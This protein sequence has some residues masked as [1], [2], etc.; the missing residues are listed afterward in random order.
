[1]HVTC[2]DWIYT[3]LYINKLTASASENSLLVTTSAIWR[4]TLKSRLLSGG[5]FRAHTFL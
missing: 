1:M 3:Y 4:K 5:F 2:T